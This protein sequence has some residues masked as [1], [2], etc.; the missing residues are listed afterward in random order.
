MGLNAQQGV[1]ALGLLPTGDRANTGLI[2]SFGAVGPGLPF[3]VM[4]PA[5]ALL[6]ASINTALTVTAGSVAASVASAT[7]LANG[8][9]IY[10]PAGLLPPGSTISGLASTN[11][12]VALPTLT[13]PGTLLANGQI[14]GLPSVKWLN[15]ATVTGPGLPAAGLTVV[16]VPVQPST[17]GGFPVSSPAGALGFIQAG[18][19]VQLSSVNVTP[20]TSP[21]GDPQF[22]QFALAAAGIPTSGADAAAIFTGAG[23]TFN[24]TVQLERSFDGGNTWPV[25]NIGGSGQLAQY[26]GAAVPPIS[27]T[28]AEP[29]EGVIYRWNCIAYTSGTIQYRIS[30]TGAAATVLPLNQLS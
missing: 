1:A 24:A 19:S 15:G 2:G 23:V 21:N 9:S 20:K 3:P 27:L 16:G 5:N 26:L 25:C 18:G 17:I 30:T 4:G 11:F 6:Y 29:E 8:A 7:G 12:N 13:L 14:I 10:S 22:F 28:F